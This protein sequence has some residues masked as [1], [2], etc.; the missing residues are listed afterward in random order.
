MQSLL[1][2]G[3]E[4]RILHDLCEVIFDKMGQPVKVRGTSQ[5]ITQQQ[6][7]EEE[8][9]NQRKFTEDILNNL[10]ADVAVFDSQH[11]YLF[12]NP[13]AI[14]DPEIRK[15]MIGKNDFDYC[16]WKGVDDM[17]AVNRRAKFNDAIESKANFSWTDE[18]INKDGRVSHIL[19]KFHPYFENGVLKFVIGYGVDVSSLKTSEINL[20]KAFEVVE[21]A[22]KGL[23]QFAFAASHDLQEPLRMVTNYLAL[24]EKKYKDILDY[25]GKKYIHFAVDGALRMRQIILD[26]LEFSRIGRTEVKSAAVNVNQLINEILV[27]FGNQIQEKGAVINIGELPVLNTFKV[28][29]RQAFQNLIGNA[30]KYQKPGNLPK[31]TIS[32]KETTMH[33][34]FSVKDNGIGINKEHFERIFVIFQRLHV[35]E[36]YSGTG[37]GLAITQKIIESVGGKIWVESAE[38]NGSKFIFTIP[39]IL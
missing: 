5:D 28:P 11:N 18:H 7:I 31:I 32:A 2:L 8:I 4:I 17:M 23:E 19:R 16:K 14:K 35:K 20:Q 34:Q 6:K 39:K 1:I 9:I 30:L 10:P 26:L 3:G 25:T 22:N 33:W 12:L 24:I 36:E 29:L 13:H 38:G 27:L 15:W 37:V 21:K